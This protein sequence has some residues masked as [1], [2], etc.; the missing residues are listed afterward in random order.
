MT[1]GQSFKPAIVNTIPNPREGDLIQMVDEL[2][3]LPLVS[4]VC[5]LPL[6]YLRDATNAAFKILH[7]IPT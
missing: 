4:M 2:E 1:F 5:R 3:G 7:A 6:A